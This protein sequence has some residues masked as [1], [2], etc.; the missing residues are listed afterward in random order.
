M[1]AYRITTYSPADKRAV[2]RFQQPLWQGDLRQNGAYLDWKYGRNP[3]LDY[4]YIFLAW[5][6]SEL[7]GMVG[8]FGASWE[9]RG[10]GRVMLPCLADTMIESR[11]R[12]GSL[13][14]S[15]LH[16]LIEKLRVDGIPWLLD[17]GDQPAAPAMLMR[18]WK[19]IGPWAVAVSRVSQAAVVYDSSIWSRAPSIRGRR[20]NIV[21]Q[22]TVAV[23]G[24]SMAEFFS[25]FQRAGHIHH[26]CDRSFFAWRFQNPLARYFYLIAQSRKLEGYLVAHQS[27][28]QDATLP[29]TI[30]ECES[31]SDEIWVD[32]VE[33]AVHL[34][35]GS[36]VIMWARDISATRVSGLES[37]GFGLNE[38]S[39]QLTK[40]LELPNLLVHSNI[41][42]PA[43]SVLASLDSRVAWDLRFVCGRSVR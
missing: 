42:L 7:V 35:R 23:N 33:A 9:V 24:A 5:K 25:Q 16:E 8:A 39:G 37:L 38:P 32:L 21:I 6:G 41:N 29:I 26:V 43:S 13:Y 4:R 34:L 2:T 10:F 40:D 1:T 17:F 27:A 30:T 18:G 36:E 3:Y 11:C 15:M 19:S 31:V 22:P 20:S 12:G 14:S 28:I